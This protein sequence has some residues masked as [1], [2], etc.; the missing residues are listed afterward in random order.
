MNDLVCILERK[1]MQKKKGRI[2]NKRKVKDDEC[3]M[4]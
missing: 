1:K 3:G 2:E 4:I